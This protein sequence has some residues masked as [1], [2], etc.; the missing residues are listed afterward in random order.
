ADSVFWM[1]PWGGMVSGM[2]RMPGTPGLGLP[3]VKTMSQSAMAARQDRESQDGADKITRPGTVGKPAPGES[4]PAAETE[5]SVTQ[6]IRRSGGSAA[7]NAA[8]AVRTAP[9]D[10]P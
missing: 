5:G 8:A 1:L 4:G 6:P 10:G 3:K 7:I 2:T 9:G